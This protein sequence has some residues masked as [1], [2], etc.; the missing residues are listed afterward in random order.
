LLILESRGP[1]DNEERGIEVS[2]GV[3]DAIVLPAGVAHCCLESEGGYEYVGLYPKG[4]P[5]WDNNFC[6]ANEE[7]TREKAAS[8][9]AVPVPEYDPITGK[10]GDLVRIWR[11]AL[12]ARRSGDNGDSGSCWRRIADLE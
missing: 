11:S 6:R 3:G 1:L 12:E 4:S 8:A 5:H 2:V 9:R 7:E 10:D